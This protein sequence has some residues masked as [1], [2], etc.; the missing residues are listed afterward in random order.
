MTPRFS[1]KYVCNNIVPHLDHSWDRKTQAD[2]KAT[3][4]L[5]FCPN[6]SDV[7]MR[8]CPERVAVAAFYLDQRKAGS[9]REVAGR[10][11]TRLWEGMQAHPSA[12]QL[13]SVTLENGSTRIHPTADLDLS[14]GF[15][16]GGKVATATMIEVRGLRER[17]AAAIEAAAALIGDDDA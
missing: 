16:S 1:N 7:D 6:A 9:T 14:T 17:V 4:A 8:W 10:A 15:I 13:T 5:G 12:D 2:D 3:K 11:A